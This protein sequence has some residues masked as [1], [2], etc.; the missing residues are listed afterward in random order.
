MFSRL[1]PMIQLLCLIAFT[2]SGASCKRKSVQSDTIGFYEG[3]PEDYD[4]QKVIGEYFLS[5]EYE[6]TQAVMITDT[7]LTT[8]SPFYFGLEGNQGMVLAK[9]IIQAGAEL[10]ILNDHFKIEDLN[11]VLRENGVKMKAVKIFTSYARKDRYTN[12]FA[13]PKNIFI[14]DF[15]P[16]FVNATQKHSEQVV[17]DFNYFQ[18]FRKNG[19]LDFYSAS[20]DL[21]DDADVKVIADAMNLTRHSLPLFFE[22]GNLIKNKQGFCLATDRLYRWNSVYDYGNE[23]YRQTSVIR[24][25]AYFEDDPRSGVLSKFIRMAPDATSRF[26]ISRSGSL[27]KRM[28]I[29][30]IFKKFVGCKKLVVIDQP[31]ELLDHSHV[32]TWLRFIDDE[33][34]LVADYDGAVLA[35]APPDIKSLAHAR[36]DF[37]DRQ[38]DFIQKELIAFGQNRVQIIRVNQPLPYR[39]DKQIVSPTYLNFLIVNGTILVPRYGNIA[40]FSKFYRDQT[41]LLTYES[42]LKAILTKKFHSLTWIDSD[43]SIQHYGALHCVTSNVFGSR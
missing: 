7:L 3:K 10:W 27:E 6:T 25:M 20:S 37:F 9:K 41:M 38:V 14:R 11:T 4:W 34:L 33:T 8:D 23:K 26:G 12:F 19:V 21:Y 42:Q 1:I 31:P 16:V 2:S 40:P 29:R 28:E 22:W 30:K 43:R 18:S 5:A 17:L 15:A 35:A 13:N 32:D 36:K 24:D 39:L